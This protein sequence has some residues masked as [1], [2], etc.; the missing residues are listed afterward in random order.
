[1]G[2]LN[3]FWHKKKSCKCFDRAIFSGFPTVVL[4]Q[5]VRDVIIP[6]SDLSGIYHVASN[7]I[8][9]CNKIH[10]CFLSKKD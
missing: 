4:A 8:S 1:M 9:K 10:T 6:R 5:I 7:P 3:G 2:Y